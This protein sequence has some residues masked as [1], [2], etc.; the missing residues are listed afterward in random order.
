MMNVTDVCSELPTV[1][2]NDGTL[3]RAKR[4]IS[5]VQEDGSGYSWN[6]IYKIDDRLIEG[7][8]F[9]AKPSREPTAMTLG[10]VSVMREGIGYWRANL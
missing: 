9:F 1:K 8:V 6:L 7:H 2:L 4:L 3:L 5:V 10:S